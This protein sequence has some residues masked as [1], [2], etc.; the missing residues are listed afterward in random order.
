MAKES[1]RRE[2]STK[3]LGIILGYAQGRRLRTQARWK[4]ASIRKTTLKEAFHT[5]SSR[6]TRGSVHKENA[7]KIENPG[8]FPHHPL[9]Q[10]LKTIPIGKGSRSSE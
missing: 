3:P 4:S 6:K 8:R 10:P 7:I 2:L 9:P 5:P 1:K